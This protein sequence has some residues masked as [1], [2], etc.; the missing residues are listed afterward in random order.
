MFSKWQWI[1]SQLLQQLW[2]RAALFGLLAVAIALLAVPLEQLIENPLPFAISSEAVA[3][4]LDILASSMLAVTTFSLGVMVT[5][6]GSASAGATPRAN[7]LVKKD[8]TSQNVLA[9]FLGSFI[10]SLV[11]IIALHMNVYGETG[12]IILFTTTIAVITLIVIT[13]LRWIEHLSKLG[14]LAE[15]TKRVEVAT[16]KALSEWQDHPCLGGKPV[17]DN[18][19]PGDAV[20]IYTD[21]VG[22]IQHIDTGALAGL[23][24]THQAEIAVLQLPGKFVHAGEAIAWLRHSLN[25]PLIT[26]IRS[27]FTIGDERSFEQDPRFGLCV[28]SEIASRALSPAVNDPGTAI[29]IL[30]RGVRV[31][32]HWRAEQPDADSIV[33]DNLLVPPL[34]LNDLLDDLLLPIARD[35]AGLVEVHIR[36]QKA[37]LSLIA[38]DAATFKDEARRIAD[39]D[40]RY[41]EVSLTLET[42]KQRLRQLAAKFS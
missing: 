38:I 37:L 17:Q 33:Y 20:A 29:D 11:G 19:I 42:D 34:R 14:R 27:A 35:A 39:V 9:T 15:T 2:L 22:Y 25:P 21:L 18:T 31:L 1:L 28:L 3:D 32:Q 8:A 40:L 26:D 12:L 7:Q 30:G 6:Y 4:I 24:S 13:I 16:Q 5:A 36:L 41:A 23:A 10:Y